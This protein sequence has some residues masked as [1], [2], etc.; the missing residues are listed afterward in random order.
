MSIIL[1]RRPSDTPT[2]TAHDDTRAFRYAFNGYNGIVKDYLNECSHTV[3]GLVFKVNS[4]E[5][6]IDGIQA[7]IDANGISINIDQLSTLR[8]YTA[9]IEFN[10]SNPTTPTVSLKASYSTSNYPVVEKGDDL[11]SNPTGTANLP[12][13]HFT[14]QDSSLS[15]VEQIASIIVPGQAQQAENSDVATRALNAD[16]ADNAERTSFSNSPWET[17]DDSQHVVVENSFYFIEFEYNDKHHQVVIYTHKPSAV[18]RTKTL[19]TIADGETFIT[20]HTYWGDNN[21]IELDGAIGG[22][23]ALWDNVS[24]MRIVRIK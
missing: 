22:N 10:F 14:S 11:T 12:L 19:T 1:L 15:N 17:L 23:Y 18:G 9:Y 20:L 4:G 21:Q 8:Y 5:I 6:V 16:N 13:Y 7:E 3:S 24:T 2:V